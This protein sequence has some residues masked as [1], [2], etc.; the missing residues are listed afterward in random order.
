M[1]PSCEGD[2]I[3]YMVKSLDLTSLKG[4]LLVYQGKGNKT[5]QLHLR[6]EKGVTP[7]PSP[8]FL[9]FK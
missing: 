6:V 8:P 2:C 1:C 5:H 9:S 4:D 7:P 3:V